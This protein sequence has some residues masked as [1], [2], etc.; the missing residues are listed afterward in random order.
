MNWSEKLAVLGRIH[1]N[2]KQRLKR[3]DNGEKLPQFSYRALK[4]I[5]PHEVDDR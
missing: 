5:S 1:A 2:E 4:L 3:L